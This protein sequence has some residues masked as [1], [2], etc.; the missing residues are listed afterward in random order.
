M[1]ST[2][3][4]IIAL[5]VGLFAA[6][7]ALSGA[8][9]GASAVAAECSALPHSEWWQIR[10]HE[11]MAKHV[12]NRHGG[13]W[14]GYLAKWNG[15]AARM[16]K[17][18]NSGQSVV[19]RSMGKTIKGDAL[20]SYVGKIKERIGVIACLAGKPARNNKPA[21]VD[22]AGLNAL[23]TS[24][25]GDAATEA[26][27]AGTDISRGLIGRAS[28]DRVQ[29]VRVDI[30]APSR[31]LEIVSLCRGSSAVFTLRNK[32]LRSSE[33]NY[34]TILAGDGEKV[35]AKRRVRLTGGGSVRFSIPGERLAEYDGR[36]MIQVASVEAHS[37][38][39]G[40]AVTC[41]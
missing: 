38:T 7:L 12:R 39:F 25:P 24:A 34:I 28:E 17:A 4:K 26:R 27:G 40:T 31:R 21:T 32:R 5:S 22:A 33:V 3:N 20:A 15:Y 8:G 23:E 30:D 13:D 37:S 19:V 6:T 29:E 11:Q 18:H 14:A 2:T 41:V 1:R 36:A 16:E 9:T 10:T 35:I